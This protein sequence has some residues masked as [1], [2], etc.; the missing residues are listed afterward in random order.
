MDVRGSLEQLETAARILM[1]IHNFWFSFI[2]NS[3]YNLFC[4]VYYQAPP[5]IVSKDERFAAE[6][7]II[8]FRKMRNA[9][10][11]CKYILGSY[12]SL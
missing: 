12:T 11:L 10:V 6:T 7:M 3:N 2:N 8:N 5:D 4:V 1:V 9:F